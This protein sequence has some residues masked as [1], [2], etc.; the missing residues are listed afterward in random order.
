M[1]KIII[2][3]S[4]EKT[5]LTKERG[6]LKITQGGKSS[7]IALDNIFSVIISANDVILT[8]TVINALTEKG[9]IIFL[10]GSSFVPESVAL[11]TT[12]H[13]LSSARIKQQINA[14]ADLNKKLW[15]T[16]IRQKIHNQAKVLDY[17]EP[18]SKDLTRLKF[19]EKNISENDCSNNEGQASKVYFKALFGKDFIRN[20]NADDL[21]IYL[22]YAYIVLRSAVIRS[23]CA[24]GLTVALGIKHCNPTNAYPLADDLI[25]PFRPVADYIV[26]KIIERHKNE[27]IALTPQIKREICS[28]LT[29]S[30]KGEHGKILLPEAISKTIHSLTESYKENKDQLYFPTLELSE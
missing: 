21:N 16:I 22:N 17:Y 1:E 24:A 12:T 26:K 11:S 4:Q 20:R 13:C 25:E 15:A 18:F 6:F 3:I 19:L 23:V 14:F 8:K 28:L 7:Q 9:I 30:L 5:S 2:E 10:C 29:F 27:E